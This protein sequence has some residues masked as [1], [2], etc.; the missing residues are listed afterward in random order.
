MKACILKPIMWNTNN[1]IS[2]SGFKSFGGYSAE[3]GFG[4]EEWNNNPNWIWRGFKV[5]HTES[6]PK[7]LEYSK[8]GNLGILMITSFHGNQYGVGIATNVYHNDDEEMLLIA[9]ELKIFDNYHQIWEQAIVRRCYN[10][11]INKF[12]KH[13]KKDYKWIRWKCP[14]EHYHWFEKPILL[15]ARKITGKGKLSVRHGIYQWVLPQTILDIVYN[16]I[17]EKASIVDWLTDGEFNY[18]LV[19]NK[20]TIQSNATLRKK[21]PHKGGSASTT[22][23]YSYWVEGQRNIEPLHAKLQAKF[24]KYLSDFGVKYTENENCIDVQYFKNKRLRYCEIKPTENIE[25]KY[26]IRIAIGQLLEYRFFNNKDATLEIVI[27]TKPTKDEIRFV[28]FLNICL[29]YFDEKSKTFLTE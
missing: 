9:D 7:L 1:Y 23:S 27:S 24:V 16:Q 19:V 10:N 3:H 13:W 20:P 8:D 12:K 29:T 28:K 17:E 11:D 6:K 5:F 15:D 25:T 4:H 2:P 14:I 26:A 18:N 21:Y 22:N